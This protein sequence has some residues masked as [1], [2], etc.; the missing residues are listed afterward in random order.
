MN[1]DFTIY[2]VSMTGSE[3]PW[4]VPAGITSIAVKFVGGSGNMRAVASGPDWQMLAG[5][6]EIIESV[7]LPGN[8]FIFIGTGAVQIRGYRM[9]SPGGV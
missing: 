6:P 4:T 2:N 7:R 3:I 5:Q 9:A 1:K 8:V